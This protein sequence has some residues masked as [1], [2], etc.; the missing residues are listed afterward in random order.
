V[1]LAGARDLHARA[2]V[3]REDE[4]GRLARGLNAMLEQLVGFIAKLQG[5]VRSATAALQERNVLLAENAQ[6]L[7]TARRDLA[8]AEQLAAAGRM[9]ASVAH[10]I[11]T[12]LNLISGYV[13]MLLEGV[14]AGSPQAARLRAVLEQITRVTTIVQGLLDEARLPPLRKRSVAP[15]ELLK[16]V[17]DL[18]RPTL[19]GANVAL[20][21]LVDD[22][23]PAV[24]ADVG[25]LEQVF[26]NLITNSLDAM[27]GGGTLTL[28][29]RRRGEQVEFQVRDTGVGIARENLSRVFEPLFTTK[30]PG[31]GTGLGLTIVKD[32]LQAHGGSVGVLSEPGQGTTVSVV[33]PT[34][35]LVPAHA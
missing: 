34:G 31:A 25:Q 27:P 6:R 33:L 28:C 10:Q 3:F 14:P 16:R 17:C 13:Q 12:P 18:A 8:R 23:V 24:E 20:E 21:L 22:D 32:V 29:A 9:A 15:G 19:E 11:G 26:L 7:F 35:T 2:K 30:K 4:L 5:E 1:R